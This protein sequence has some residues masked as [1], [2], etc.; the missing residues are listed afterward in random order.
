[1]GQGAAPGGV[2]CGGGAVSCGG[3]EAGGGRGVWSWPGGAMVG[4]RGCDGQE[5]RS[6]P[7]RNGQRPAR[8][9]RHARP[10]ERR[11]GNGRVTDRASVL[12]GKGGGRGSGGR[13]AAGM[14]LPQNGGRPT[15]WKPVLP[16]TGNGRAGGKLLPNRTATAGG[17]SPAAKYPPYISRQ[18]RTA[19]GREAWG[20]AGHEGPALPARFFPL[21]NGQ[22][23][24]G[25]F[26]GGADCGRASAASY[27]SNTTER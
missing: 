8:M 16:R 18:Q 13:I 11:T 26:A 27:R 1:M 5:A 7:T 21:P 12:P 6:C 9:R 23:I 24:V 17:H 25:A 2:R 22:Y 20:V 4:G 14:P 15:G 3:W 19:N 10:T